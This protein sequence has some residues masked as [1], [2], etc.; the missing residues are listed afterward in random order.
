[1]GSCYLFRLDK[2]DI[3]DATRKGGMARFMNHCCEPNAFAR[4][5]PTDDEGINK[6]IIIMAGRDIQEG[7]EVTYD[8]KFPLEENKL[9][10]YCGAAKCKGYMN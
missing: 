8:Y 1:V 9:R 7:E 3:I 6:H 10:C 2:T 5:I 4:V